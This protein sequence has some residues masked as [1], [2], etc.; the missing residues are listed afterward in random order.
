VIDVGQSIGVDVRGF[1]ADDG[2]PIKGTVELSI[3]HGPNHSSQ[4]INLDANGR[5]RAMF[6]NPHYGANFIAAHL[7]TEQGT[8]NDENVVTVEPRALSGT[9]QHGATVTIN[10]DRNRY[11]PHGRVLF[12]AHAP[13]AVGQAFVSIDNRTVSEA[14]LVPIAHGA[15]QGAITL[16]D[17]Q[18]AVEA[19]VAYVREGYVLRGTVPLEIDGP[20]HERQID[21]TSDAG[22]YAPGTT[23]KIRINDG[24]A[25]E[26]AT[27]IV[28]LSDEIPSGGADFDSAGDVLAFG[29]ATTQSSA[30]DDPPWHAW[31]SPVNSRARDLF[32]D[33]NRRPGSTEAPA[34]SDAY[35]RLLMW[36]AERIGSSVD[37]AV[38]KKPGRYILSI[39]RMYDDG[40]VGASTLTLEVV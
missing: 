12:D 22:T 1:A 40:D 17:P 15:V 34:L 27:T 18:G 33:I 3:S 28:R 37:V 4:T 26:V 29:G 6:R 35:A 5:G 19:G 13:G 7:I 25:H 30:T 24:A 20:G 23:A 32:G 10:T 14:M 9:A 16:R 31:V 11:A 38:P 21:L 2:R 39:L 36:R 8:A